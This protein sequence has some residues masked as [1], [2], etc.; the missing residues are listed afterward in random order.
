MKSE[1]H[2]IFAVP[3]IKIFSVCCQIRNLCEPLLGP[4][5]FVFYVLLKN[6][7]FSQEIIVIVDNEMGAEEQ[8]NCAVMDAMATT[9]GMKNA[10][11]QSI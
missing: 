11:K 10:F 9:A 4:F 5:Y 8:P 1:L 6:I 2:S 3:G 7:F